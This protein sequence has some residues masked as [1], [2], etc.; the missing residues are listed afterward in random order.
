MHPLIVILAIF[1]VAGTAWA[2]PVAELDYQGKILISDLPFTGPGYFKFAIS[3][4]LSSTNYWS[5]DGSFSLEPASP[6]TGSVYNGVFS[7]NL[8][9]ST[10]NAINP[11]IFHNGN[12][13]YLR[14]W[15]SDSGSSFTE[16][17]PSQKLISSPYAIN[18]DKLDGLDASQIISAATNAFTEVDPV[19]S[20]D[21]A[22]G[23]NL[24]SMTNPPAEWTLDTGATNLSPSGVVTGS[25]DEATRTMIVGSDM[26]GYATGTPLYTE[27]DPIYTNDLANG[28]VATGAPVYVETDPVWTND[29]AGGFTM[30]GDIDMAWNIIRNG[31]FIGDGNKLTNLSVDIDNVIW[32]ATNGSTTGTGTI[33]HPRR[34]PQSGYD[35]AAAK[36]T[37]TPAAVAICAGSYGGLVMNAG[38]VHVL[39]FSRPQLSGLTVMSPSKNILGKQRV[40]NLIFNGVATV[41]ADGGSDVK[42]HNCRFEEALVINGPRVEVQD[43]YATGN[44]G[45]AVTVGTGMIRIQEIAL[46]NSSIFLLNPSFPALLVNDQV[47]FFETIGCEISNYGGGGAV[48]DMQAVIPMGEPPHLYSHCVING[49]E[50]GT[51][52]PP[53][54]SPAVYDS[55][56]GGSGPTICFVQNAVWGDV[57][58]FS[59]AQFYA[60]NIVYGIINKV[61]GSTVGWTQAGLGNPIDASGN[62]EHFLIYP[63][64]GSGTTGFPASW[65]D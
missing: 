64:A 27:T 19:W 43:C 9:D 61:G 37:N 49:P 42:F 39:G 5:N 14:V 26:T 8:G 20:A 60:N 44:D 46:Y 12:D 65:Q 15:F 28:T 18:A 45:P 56:Y 24:S 52:L 38:N 32:V 41:A 54:M 22:A 33:E 31:I 53:G 30:G 4:A 23:L 62:T 1:I 59:N 58:A 50:T 40:E 21:Y 55:N 7:M 57:G 16:M 3:D 10:M 6:V 17:L 47:S 34:D 13:L 29:K 63:N 25:Y 11:N 48:E 2:N 51:A 35:L 36:F